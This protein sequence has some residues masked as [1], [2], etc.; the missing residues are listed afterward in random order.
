MYALVASVVLCAC[1][2]FSVTFAVMRL[3]FTMLRS[4]LYC[5]SNL[6]HCCIAG[7]A[8]G[9]TRDAILA[10][11]SVHKVVLEAMLAD[12]VMGTDDTILTVMLH[13]HKDQVRLA[14]VPVPVFMHVLRSYL[15]W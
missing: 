12:G 13:Q 11:V 15:P 4:I 5:V 14:A 8:F 1:G 2:E 7:F 3:L 9:G 10:S 6:S